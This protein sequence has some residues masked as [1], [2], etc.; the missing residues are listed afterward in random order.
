MAVVPFHP[1][2]LKSFA[3]RSPGPRAMATAPEKPLFGSSLRIRTGGKGRY[4]DAR[5]DLRK[6]SICQQ[7]RTRMTGASAEDIAAAGPGEKPQG[8][9]R[10]RSACPSRARGRTLTHPSTPGDACHGRLPHELET[11]SMAVSD[12]QRRGIRGPGPGGWLD[13]PRTDSTSHTLTGCGCVESGPL[14]G[15]RAGGSERAPCGSS[16]HKNDVSASRLEALRAA[17]PLPAR[18]EKSGGR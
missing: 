1:S 18:P 14:P 12:W 11:A 4:P 9:E 8:R 10:S 13:V 2:L 16:C 7:S 5:R 6:R 15:I 17:P 3:T